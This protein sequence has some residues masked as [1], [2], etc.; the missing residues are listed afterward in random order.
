MNTPSRSL[1]EGRGRILDAH[2]V[3]VRASDGS[4]RQL[5]TKNILVATGSHAVK[6]PL[7]G[8]VRRPQLGRGALCRLGAAAGTVL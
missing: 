3:E 4:V 6:I 8:A 2:T 5:R 7:P 1:A